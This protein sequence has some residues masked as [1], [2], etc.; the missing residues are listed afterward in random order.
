MLRDLPIVRDQHLAL[1][2]TCADYIDAGKLTIHVSQVL[3][4]AQAKVAHD[5]LE[6][7]H[8]TGKVVLVI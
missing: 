4:L 5:L 3:P 8:T 1:L 2:K 6:T 7:G